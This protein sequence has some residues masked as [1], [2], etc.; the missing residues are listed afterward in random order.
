M[1]LIPAHC[2]SF[3]LR[4]KEGRH[5][6]RRFGPAVNE[7]EILGGWAHSEKIMLSLIHLELHSTPTPLPTMWIG[8]TPFVGVIWPFSSNANDQLV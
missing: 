1:F 6:P 5:W 4:K 8:L 3:F 2:F 7:Y